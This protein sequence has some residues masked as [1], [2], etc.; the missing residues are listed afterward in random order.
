LATNVLL[1][2][3]LGHEPVNPTRRTFPIP[4]RNP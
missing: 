4:N 2:K 1:G 3:C